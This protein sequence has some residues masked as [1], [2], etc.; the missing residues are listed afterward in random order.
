[1]VVPGEGSGP[2]VCRLDLSGWLPREV[3][4][5]AHRSSEFWLV[6]RYYAERDGEP[7]ESYTCHLNG[8]PSNCM[9]T[10]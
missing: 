7:G 2:N 10:Q 9:P 5:P 8:G 1:M 3:L 6:L 4:H